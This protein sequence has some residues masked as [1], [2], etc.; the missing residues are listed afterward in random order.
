MS[1]IQR[2][3]SKREKHG[4]HHSSKYHDHHREPSKDKVIPSPSLPE[5][6]ARFSCPSLVPPLP[7]FRWGSRDNST[8]HSSNSSASVLIGVA[9]TEDEYFDTAMRASGANSSETSSTQPTPSR[10]TAHYNSLFAADDIQPPDKDEDKKVVQ[11][12]YIILCKAY[13]DRS[14]YWRKELP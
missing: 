5:R 3:L 9:G 4:S 7:L 1:G 6:S 2:F 13:G 14:K 8:P 10:A 12:S 11:L